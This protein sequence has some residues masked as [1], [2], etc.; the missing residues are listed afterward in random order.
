MR[1]AQSRKNVVRSPANP[2]RICW[3][4]EKYCP[5]DDLA[6]GNG[7]IRTPHPCELFGDDWLEW[8]SNRQQRADR[9]LP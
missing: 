2:A 3:G 9:E 4:C 6:C 5:A 8:A 1:V 7:S